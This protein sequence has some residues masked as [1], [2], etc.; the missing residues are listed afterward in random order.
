MTNYKK[1]NRIVLTLGMSDRI[2]TRKN[3][4]YKNK[5]WYWFISVVYKK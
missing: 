5:Y 2:R 3:T 1:K 4:K